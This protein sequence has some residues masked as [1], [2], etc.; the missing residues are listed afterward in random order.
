MSDTARKILLGIFLIGVG[1][2]ATELWLLGHYE[3]LDQ[4]IPLGLAG[5]GAIAVLAAAAM[6]TTATLRALQFVMLL[7]VLSGF[8]G[9]WFHFQA[10][11]EFQLEMDPSLRGWALFRKA[12]VAKAPPAL[13]PGSMIQL[14]LIGLAYTFKHPVLRRGGSSDPPEETT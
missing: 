2:I 8:L 1:G 11:T 10:T 9:M 5:A 6:P 12:I 4:V 14:G 13:A 3:E 7:C